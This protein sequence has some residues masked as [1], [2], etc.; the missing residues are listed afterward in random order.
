MIKVS[1]LKFQYRKND[2]FVLDDLSFEMKEGTVNVLLGLNGCGKTTLLKI[3]ANILTPTE[4][5]VELDGRN[6]AEYSIEERSKKIAYVAQKTSSIDDFTVFDYLSFGLVNTTKF[7]QKPSAEKLAEIQEYAKL[8]KIEGLL[9]KY[10]SEVSGGERQLISI[11]SALLQNTKVIL[12][13][14]PTSALDL[15]NQALILGCLKDICLR[16]GKTITLSTHNPNHALFLD[17]NVFVM[18]NGKFLYIGE[19][20]NIIRTDLLKEVYGDDICLS[21]EQKYEEIS[22]GKR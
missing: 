1:G 2:K 9:D 5:K 20:K 13:D 18:K 19:A 12:L 7:Y 6:L 16:D 14:E 8:L 21:K 4:G 22:F 15:S 11:C 17:S 3:L 10:L